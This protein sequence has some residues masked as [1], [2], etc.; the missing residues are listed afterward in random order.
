LQFPNG[1]KQIIV[2][3]QAIEAFP[4]VQT[5][6]VF[7]LHSNADIQYYTN[8][9]RILWRNLVELQPR[10]VS[11]GSGPTREEF[12]ESTAND[13]LG[14]IPEPFDLPVIRK[15]I[16][17][18]SPIQVVLLQELERWNQYVLNLYLCRIQYSTKNLHYLIHIVSGQFKPI[19]LV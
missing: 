3:L 11:K 14:S 12:V 18:P 5:P 6:E 4:L 1:A 2:H 13:I 15:D 19:Q 10:T 7:G 17:V 9:T 8:A 16:G